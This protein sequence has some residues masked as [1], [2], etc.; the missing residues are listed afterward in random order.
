[1]PSRSHINSN[2]GLRIVV[3]DCQRELPFA[4]DYFDRVL[5]IHVLEHL[6]NLPAALAEIAV[7]SNP[8]VRSPLSFRARVALLTLGRRLTTK[9][10]FEKRY[11]TDYEWMIGYDHCNTAREIVDLLP[12]AFSVR[13]RAFFPMRVP[14]IDAN[15]VIGLELALQP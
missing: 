5:A 10:I 7:S 8:R 15:L 11:N 4:T 14:S 9:R 13:R 6:D 1:M 3:G 12:T 2:D